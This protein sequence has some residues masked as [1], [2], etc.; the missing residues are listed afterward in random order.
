MI[1]KKIE[2][3]REVKRHEAV[4]VAKHLWQRYSVT[5]MKAIITVEKYSSI[6][7]L[8]VLIVYNDLGIRAGI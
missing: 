5:S 2:T 1:D 4:P 8:F 3:S 7:M 6:R